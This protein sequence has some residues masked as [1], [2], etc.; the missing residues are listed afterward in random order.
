MHFKLEY[1]IR[2]LALPKNKT[3]SFSVKNARDIDIQ[4]RC[5]SEEEQEK[6]HSAFNAFSIAETEINVSDKNEEVFQKIE[7]NGFEVT[8]E[9]FQQSYKDNE[10]KE[11][12][13][14]GTE[15]FPNHFNDF[16]RQVHRELSDASR[17]VVDAIRWRTNTLGPHSPISTR[18]MSWSRD[19]AF[20]HPAPSEFSV[21]VDV[22][23]VTHLSEPVL[24]D[25]EAL[26]NN[27]LQEPVHHHLFREAW[28][29]RDGNPRSSLVVGLAALEISL[30]TTIGELVPNASWLADNLPTPPVTR[31]LVEYL[32][33]LPA[34]NAF[35]GKVL[36]PPKEVLEKIKKAVQI[37][38]RVAHV[39]GTPP[40]VE[41]LDEL[42]AAVQET[43]WLLDYYCGHTWA[44]THLSEATMSALSEQG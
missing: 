29:Q 27:N 28:A 26:V 6:G 43:M 11:I 37:R 21:R 42:L 33:E 23:S 25:I 30:K 16:I 24:E 3:L 34:R 40:S 17:F 12:L 2:E 18:G 31:M 44:L 1:T 5:P 4:I 7:A 41:V 9:N 20:W 8:R 19:K 14:P 38:N 15:G 36:P 10:G 13:L 35:D 22:S 32:P 39:G